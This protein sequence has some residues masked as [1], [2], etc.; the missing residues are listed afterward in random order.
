[1]NNQKLK[2]LSENQEF[3]DFFCYKEDKWL[4]YAELDEKLIAVF[5]SIENAEKEFEK[6]KAENQIEED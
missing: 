6:Y 4:Q 3:L 2:A 5:G 1:M